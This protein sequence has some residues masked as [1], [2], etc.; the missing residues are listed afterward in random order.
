MNEMQYEDKFSTFI[1]K[2]ENVQKNQNQ[3]KL[4]INLW[5][6]VSSGLLFYEKPWVVWDSL[7]IG[8]EKL[9]T[10][11]PWEIIPRPTASYKALCYSPSTESEYTDICIRR[12]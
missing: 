11:P 6:W 1:Y 12:I 4:N 8:S 7:S 2:W 3:W 5:P 9:V 10:A